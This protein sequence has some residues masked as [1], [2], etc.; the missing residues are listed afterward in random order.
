MVIIGCQ[1]PDL[2]DITRDS[3]TPT[4]LSE[5][6]LMAIASAGANK[7]LGNTGKRWHLWVSDAKSA[8]LQGEQDNSERSGPLHLAT[9]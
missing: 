1:D 3:P 4:R 9:H 6:L 7:D 5:T 2:F 8:F